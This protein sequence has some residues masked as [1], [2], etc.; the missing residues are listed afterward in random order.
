MRKSS[1]LP[2]DVAELRW[3]DSVADSFV[4]TVVLDFVVSGLRGTPQ[5]DGMT[6]TNLDDEHERQ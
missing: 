4:D 2:V 1:R 3:A 5:R 6:G